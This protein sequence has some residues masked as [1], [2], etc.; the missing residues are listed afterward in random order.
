MLRNIKEIPANIDNLA[1]LYVSNIKDDKIEIKNQ[2]KDSLLRL[3]KE[4]LIERNNETYKFLTDDEQ[5]VNREIKNLHIDERKVT[6]YINSIVFESIYRDTKIN[7]RNKNFPL[8]KIVDNIKYTQDYEI[9]IKIISTL[10]ENDNRGLIMDSSREE[11]L[12]YLL[13]DIST[14]TYEEITNN[15]KVEEYRRNKSGL[16]LSV[17]TDDILR[18]KQ[19]EIE[20]SKKRLITIIRELIEDADMIIAGNKVNINIKEPKSK[21]NEALIQVIN[22]IFT[23]LPYIEENFNRKDI[24][25]LF[26]ENAQSFLERKDDFINQRVYDEFKE[27]FLKKKIL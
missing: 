8:T 19:R 20:N 18:V 27:F 17:K 12:V 5:E 1:T 10:F 23:K 9:G 3:E 11:N 25:E 22:N 14:G 21:I 13:L 16:D 15:L 7:Y 26:N 6:D 4:T 2:I 24:E